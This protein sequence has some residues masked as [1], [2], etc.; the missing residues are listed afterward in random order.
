MNKILRIAKVIALGVALTGKQ[1]YRKVTG[2]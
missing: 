2:K 1:I